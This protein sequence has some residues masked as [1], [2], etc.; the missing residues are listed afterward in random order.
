MLWSLPH[1]AGPRARVPQIS[2]TLADDGP[3]LGARE[4]LTN[5]Y[6][7]K[8]ASLC[9]C[10][11]AETVAHPC[12]HMGTTCL[13]TTL[14]QEMNWTSDGHVVDALRAHTEMHI[15]CSAS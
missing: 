1:R 14:I 13:N 11:T 12:C 2:Q 9:V 6:V 15:E 8:Q 3:C 4:V 5:K 7:I 10:A